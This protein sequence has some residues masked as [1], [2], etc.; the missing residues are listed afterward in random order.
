VLAVLAE[1]IL[2]VV[3]AVPAALVV[4]EVQALLLCVIQ[5]KQ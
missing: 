2:V 1:Q 4:P 5:L 3:V